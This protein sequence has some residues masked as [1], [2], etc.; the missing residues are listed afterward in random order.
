[1]S[2]ITVDLG[3]K[4][5]KRDHNYDI[6]ELQLQELSKNMEAIRKE[7]SASFKFGSL[8]ICIF[9]NVKNTFP[10]FGKVA[11]KTNRFVTQ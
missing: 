3:Y 6:A 1:M 8:I 11:W 10:T 9:F 4:I 2:C 7:K 5:V